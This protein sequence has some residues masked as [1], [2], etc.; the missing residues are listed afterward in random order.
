M[1]WLI[2]TLLL[3]ILL[4][5]FKNLKHHLVRKSITFLFALFVI[6]LILMFAS[7]QFDVGKMFSKD[8][9][10][11]KTGAAVT[12]TVGKNIDTPSIKSFFSDILSSLN[13]VT[14]ETS[15]QSSKNDFVR[16]DK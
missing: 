12:E 6:L 3:L 9:L 14:E 1:N 16:I 8:S 15:Q 4:F 2:L 5:F 13:N 7:S 10:M 11:A